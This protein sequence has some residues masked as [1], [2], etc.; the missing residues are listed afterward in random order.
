MNI[1]ALETLHCDAGWR[2]FSFVK[3]TTDTGLVGWSEFQEGFGSPGVSAAIEGLRPLVVGQ[4]PRHTEKIYWDLFAATRPAVGG[5]P[6]KR[7]VPSRTPC[8]TS[9]PSTTAF[10]SM[11]FWAVPCGIDCGFIGRTAA[12]IESIGR[13]LIHTL[14]SSLSMTSRLSAAR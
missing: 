2:N 7:S 4:D 11:N 3:L 8:W 6:G 10:P 14:P 5:S 13:R 9:R 1:T 12:P